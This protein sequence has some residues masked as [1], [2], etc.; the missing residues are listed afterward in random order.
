MQICQRAHKRH[1]KSHF[2][3]QLVT[4]THRESSFLGRQT[5]ADPPSSC[6]ANRPSCA[7]QVLAPRM[8]TALQ[9]LSPPMVKSQ[10]PSALDQ[11]SIF[12]FVTTSF[13]FFRFAS[14]PRFPLQNVLSSCPSHQIPH[15]IPPHHP[16]LPLLGPSPPPSSSCFH[17]KL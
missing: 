10:P 8:D 5:K 9:E 12:L 7:P 14:L 1:N 4:Q 6:N 3:R 2:S 15:S 17:P 13:E 11:R 16:S